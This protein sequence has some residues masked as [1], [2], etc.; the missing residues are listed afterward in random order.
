MK[1]SPNLDFL[2]ATAVLFVLASHALRFLGLLEELPSRW[3]GWL[4][5]MFFFVHTSL[6]LMQSLE[7]QQ[8]R[9]SFEGLVKNF[10]L[11]RIFRIYPLSIFSVLVVLAFHIPSRDV[12][13]WTFIIEPVSR[14][15]IATNLLLVQNLFG[16]VSFLGVLWSLPFELQMYIFLPFL[17]LWTQ[18]I[19]F[20]AELSLF[21]IGLVGAG[22]LQE[23]LSNFR[24]AAAMF[25][26]LRFAPHFF[27]GVIAYYLGKRTTARLPGFLWPPAVFLL[28]ALFLLRPS[29]KMG[30]VACLILGCAIPQF[31]ELSNRWVRGITHLIA[32]YSYGIYL[33][34][35][36]C[37][38]VAYGHF[39]NWPM[40]ARAAL[41]FF[42]LMA[43]P[44]LLYH[45][46]E[47][48]MIKVG[49][50]IGERFRAA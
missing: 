46:I 17:F 5:V 27:P 45:T 19:R 8:S 20:R 21:W 10:Y 49:T 25:S 32:K 9:F 30:W 11:R 13:K 50:R 15:E 18:K 3:L 36:F 14:S 37:L 38:W 23:Y 35:L 33:T 40:A 2:R 39:A 12:E 6:V 16:R 7:R 48:P 42:L 28:A 1:E 43:V 26:L 34:H 41:F 47:E 31:R 44:A 4:G 29:W 22:M 24:H